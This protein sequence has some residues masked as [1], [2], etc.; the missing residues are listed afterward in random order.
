MINRS[1]YQGFAG[2]G[3]QLGKTGTIDAD[4]SNKYH[5]NSTIDELASETAIIKR[6]SSLSG[7][8]MNKSFEDNINRIIDLAVDGDPNAVKALRDSS[9][10]LGNAVAGI[11]NNIGP[12]KVIIDGRITRAWNLIKDGITLQVEKYCSI[13]SLI[14]INDLVVPCGMS[15]SS[16][17][18]A[19]A[20]VLQDMFGG[21]YISYKH[22]A[23]KKLN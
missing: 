17:E 23:R 4:S 7:N 18:G 19:L 5:T 1:L 11:I 15:S 10:Y 8:K 3:G 20:L 12:E 2:F 16:V 9:G 13:Q 6:Y 22:F 21:Y 14:N